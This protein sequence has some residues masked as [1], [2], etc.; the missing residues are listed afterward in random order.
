MGRRKKGKKG[1]KKDIDWAADEFFLKE[2]SIILIEHT[3]ECPIFSKKADEFKQFMVQR[4]PERKFELIRNSN[5]KQT[6]RPGAFEIQFCQNARTSAHDLW[7]GIE[8]GPPRRDKFPENYEQLLPEV[9][10]VLKKVYADPVKDDELMND[11]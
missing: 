9:T 8:R 6:P 3:N 5:G 1:K 11:Y 10:A 4:F 2:R 7:S